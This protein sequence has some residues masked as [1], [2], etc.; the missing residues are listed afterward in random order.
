[1]AKKTVS[2]SRKSPASTAK[3]ASATTAK[4]AKRMNSV[5]KR[6]PNVQVKSNK[7]VFAT[8]ERYLAHNLHDRF[9]FTFSKQTRAKLV[10]YG[11]WL[12]TASVV[13]VSPQLMNLAKNGSLMTISGFFNDIFFNQQSWVIL[14]AILLNILLLVDGLNGLFHKTRRGWTKVYITALITTVYIMSQLV[15]NLSQP[16][17]PILSLLVALGI[18]F[19]LYDVRDYY[20]VK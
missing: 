6:V 4:K 10:A 17:A 5:S 19:T 9:S 15:Q 14:V 12:A 1:M 7:E 3:R 11:P 18:L 20:A 2:T 13:L 8:I 16:A